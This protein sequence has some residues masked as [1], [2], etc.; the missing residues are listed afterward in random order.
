M[1]SPTSSVSSKL[2]ALPRGSYFKKDWKIIKKLGSGAFGSVYEAFDLRRQ[3]RFAMKGARHA[4]GLIEFGTMDGM[5]YIAMSLVG[6]NL[7]DL[8]RQCPRKR[9]GVGTTTRLAIQCLDAIQELHN[10]GYLH[11]DVKPQNY[12]IGLHAYDRHKVYLLD[13]G[14]ARKFVKDGKLRT[15]RRKPGFCG[16]ITYASVNAHK[17]RELGRHDDLL[18]LF[19]MVIEFIRGHLPWSHV[20]D[21]RT[22]GHMKQDLPVMVFKFVPDD[23]A[24]RFR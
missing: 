11:R 21:K 15:K 22:C 3:Q 19:Y 14:L 23:H 7:E 20:H 18:S 13:F 6:K 4:C 5:N 9:F 12:A 10:I 1:S 24:L 8:R 2:P 17:G 16:T